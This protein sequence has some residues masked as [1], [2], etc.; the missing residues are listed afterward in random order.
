MEL[1]GDYTYAEYARE[2]FFQLLFVCMI[3]MIL[4]LICLKLFDNNKVLK[5]FLMIISACT[6]IMIASSLFRMIMYV[7]V[8]QLSY[9]RYMVLFGLIV[10]TVLM[11]GICITIFK[12][13]FPLFRYCTLAV[14]IL[15]LCF[16]FS[17]PAYQIAKYNLSDRYDEAHIDYTYINSYLCA[18]ATPAIVDA[19]ERR[20]STEETVTKFTE[21]F[22]KYY[23]EDYEGFRHINFSY[24][25]YFKAVDMYSHY[26]KL[27][28][29]SDKA[30][31][32]I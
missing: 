19:I 14:T 28:A 25:R 6:F 27:D 5:I 29:E 31:D 32:Y 8:Y 12:S 23:K 4:V 22:E 20:G 30:N 24:N 9:L 17:K 13:D 15:Y 7:E 26:L 16:A 3:N 1:P 10:I 11:L 21:Y 18:D 2:G